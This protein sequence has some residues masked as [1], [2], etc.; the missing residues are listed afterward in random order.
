MTEIYQERNQ[1]NKFASS[2]NK[3]TIQG[4]SKKSGQI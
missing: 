4:V 3:H 2:S 1:R